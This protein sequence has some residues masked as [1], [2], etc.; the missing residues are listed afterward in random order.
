[1][2]LRSH[3]LRALPG[4]AGKGRTSHHWSLWVLTGVILLAASALAP[5][6]AATLTESTDIGSVDPAGSF[7]E[8]NG[9]YT[10]RGSG[11]DI[12]GSAD[13]GHFV[14]QRVKG[15]V[16]ITAHFVSMEAVHYPWTKMGPMIRASEAEDAQNLF[17]KITSGVGVRIQGRNDDFPNTQSNLPP[18]LAMARPQPVWLRVQRVGQT[19]AG[20]YS[21]D[22]NVWYYGGTAMTLSELPEEALVGIAVT[23]H[24]NGEL[25][26]GVFDNVTIQPG[27]QLVTGIK[28]CVGTSGVVLTWSPLTAAESYNVYRAPAGETDPAKFVLANDKAITSTTFTD[29]STTLVNNQKYTYAIV[30]VSKSADGQSV[31]GG[32]A[33]IQA[34]PYVPLAPPG[35][36][37][38]SFDENPNNDVDFDGGC[39]PA[40]GAYYNPTTGT[41]TLRG[42]G[43]N[44]LHN[45]VDQFNFTHTEVTGNFQ[46][47]VQ[48]LTMPTRTTGNARAGLMIREGLTPGARRADLVMR[49]S[50]GGLVFEWRDAADAGVTQA[51]APLIPPAELAVPLWLRLTRDKDKITAEYSLDGANWK[52]ADDPQ[53]QVTLEGL[54]AKVNVGLAITSAQSQVGRQIT[55]AT[56]QNLEVK[57]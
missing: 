19:A 46:V 35:F 32:R 29:A 25:A 43:P 36:T 44:G 52:G 50:E 55:E 14:F 18:V 7:T 38:T 13:N 28:S 56:F 41:I 16:T 4:I 1:M 54:A 45:D 34:A 15:D 12:E 9:V 48:A 49:A 17:M 57:Q 31:E 37:V 39:V 26:T 20:F 22:G 27:A 8:A 53:N 2:V 47:S 6:F 11:S 30:P 21:L 51:A 42:S 5:A 23:S 3:A 33:G 24:Q 10:I 40:L